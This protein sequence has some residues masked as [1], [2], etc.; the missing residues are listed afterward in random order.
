MIKD[1]IQPMLCEVGSPFDSDDFIFEKKLDG[2]RILFF[3]DRKQNYFRIQNRRLYDITK[4]YPEFSN[5]DFLKEN[6][7]SVILDGELCLNEGKTCDFHDEKFKKRTHIKSSIKS[8]FLS[9]VSPLT[10]YVFDI[11]FLNGKD[12]RDLS[13]M[14]RKEILKGVIEETERVKVLDFVKGNGINYYE[15]LL[16]NGFE[17]CVAK[18]QDSK[19]ENKRSSNWLKI[20]PLQEETCVVLGWN[21]KSGRS[22]YGSVKT[23]K[24]D[25]GL[26][27]VK[28]K[29]EYDELVKKYGLGNFKVK[30]V[31]QEILP[32][33]KMRFPVFKGWIV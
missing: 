5:L 26:L 14:E 31:C 9:K 15:E 12:L 28:H 3:I 27:S 16:K 24:G 33:G 2:E 32:S 10:Y 25:V 18:K 20:K 6:V 30:V 29:E 4:N 19:Y 13:L 21:E 7:E 22:V 17:G 8:K 11:M 23:D 1:F